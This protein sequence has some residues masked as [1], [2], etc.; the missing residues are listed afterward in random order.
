MPKLDYV[1]L[2]DVFR[3]DNDITIIGST[4]FIFLS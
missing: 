1:Y 2:P 3:Y 4:H